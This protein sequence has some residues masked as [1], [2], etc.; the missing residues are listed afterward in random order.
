M[1]DNLTNKLSGAFAGF[2]GKKLT[3]DNI[4]VAIRE[5]RTAL[6]DADVA[7][8]TVIKFIEAVKQKALGQ[9]FVAAVRPGDMLIKF[10]HEE[11]VALMGSESAGLTLK[12]ASKPA[13]ILMAGLQGTGKTTTVA[14][15]AKYLAERDEMSVATVSTDV[16]RPAAIE[17]LRVLVDALPADFVDSNPTESPLDI[18]DRAL[19]RAK[20][21]E[22]DVLLV[23]TAGRLTLDDELMAEI[24]SL[25]DRLEPVETLFVLDAMTGQDAA[26]TAA[27]FDKL[28][29]LTGVVLTK[30]DGDTRGGAVLSVRAVTNKPIKFLGT[31]EEVDGLEL[32]HPERMA[33]R[34]L[35]MGDVLG[36]VEA[37][38]RKLDVQRADRMVKK[39][40]R[41]SAFTF[42]DMRDQIDQLTDMGGMSALL[43]RLPNMSQAR[44]NQADDSVMK[45]HTVI[46][47]SMT[48]RERAFPNLLNVASR[49]Q[50]IARGSGTSIQDVNLTLRKFKQMQKMSKKMGRVSKSRRMME[51][52]GRV[53]QQN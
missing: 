28:L 11:L 36:L 9:E 10:V 21:R 47:D 44:L 40:M 22:T 5:V 17:Q 50:R 29:P 51:Q 37:A 49:K 3:E 12:D 14:K 31:G 35:G 6:L 19:K 34:I 30:A 20:E 7:M 41:G 13:V 53:L 27:R 42:D 4:T 15:L 26:R 23:D 32:F 8:E 48:P 52:M 16:Y 2:R 33:S 46:I 1:F 39:I 38:E 24:K 45:K 43:E 25:S 18:V